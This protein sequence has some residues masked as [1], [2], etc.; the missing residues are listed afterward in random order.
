MKVWVI[1]DGALNAPILDVM[2][3][4]DDKSASDVITIWQG[5]Y[6]GRLYANAFPNALAIEATHVE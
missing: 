2:T 6:L 3:S 4:S 1:R 5:S